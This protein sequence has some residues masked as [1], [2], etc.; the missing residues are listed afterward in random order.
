MGV[1]VDDVLG[2]QCLDAGGAFGGIR[3]RYRIKIGDDRMG[4]VLQ[5]TGTAVAHRKYHKDR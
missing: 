1:A 2:G 5:T 3:N 4:H